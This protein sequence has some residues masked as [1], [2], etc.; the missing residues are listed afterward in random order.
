MI[1]GNQFLQYNLCFLYLVL[2]SGGINNRC[3]Q[4]LSRRIYNGKLTAGSKSRVPS[5]HNLS[6]NRRSHKKL[7]QILSENTNSPVFRLFRQIIA[8]F[9]FNGRSNESV[10]CICNGILQNLRGIRL[11]VCNDFLLKITEN[12]LGRS[13]NLYHQ[14]FLILT[15]VNGKGPMSRNLTEWFV[16]VIIHLIDRFCFCILGCGDKLSRLHGKFTDIGTIIRLIRNHF[17]NN[18]H[19]SRKCFLR[20]CYFLLG[21]HV[22]CSFL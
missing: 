21:I 6:R 22:F 2:R 3:I 14:N 17:R 1:L 8:D 20:S 10:I 15:T 16:I 13:L 18:I 5:Q 11:L 4:N 7:F 9:T 12:V 19:C